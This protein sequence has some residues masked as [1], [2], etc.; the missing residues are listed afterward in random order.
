[1]TE[2]PMASVNPGLRLV[3]VEETADSKPSFDTSAVF[4]ELILNEIRRRG[5]DRARR[6]ELIAYAAQLGVSAPEMNLLISECRDEL[7]ESDNLDDVGAALDLLR[8]EEAAAARAADWALFGMVTLKG[9][10]VALW[11]VAGLL[12]VDWLLK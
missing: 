1:M 11:V 2:K 10:T 9:M 5:L 3:P 4:R 6:R 7:M 8:D 12:L